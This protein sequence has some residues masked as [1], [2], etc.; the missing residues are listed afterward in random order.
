MKQTRAL[1]VLM[2]LA[3]LSAAA[4]V[5]EKAGTVIEATNAA[6]PE[7]V[8]TDAVRNYRPRQGQAA[9]KPVQPAAPQYDSPA[10]SL[11]A[12]AEDA[13]SR[14]FTTK[15]NPSASRDELYELLY[16]SFTDYMKCMDDLPADKKEGL[17]EKFR[18]MRPEFE[19]GGI[20]FS[21][22]GDNTKASKYLECYLMIP[23]L[24]LLAGEQFSRNDNYPAYVYNVAV[25][26][27]NARDY[28]QA[29]TYFAEY[30]E[31]GTKSHQQA[32]YNALARDLHILNRLDDEARVLDEGIMNYPNDLDLLKQGID[33]SNQRGNDTKATELLSRALTLAP[34]DASLQLYKAAIDDRKGDFESALPTLQAFYEQNPG[35]TQLKKQLAFCHYNL[36]GSLINQSNVAG[37]ATDFQTKRAKATEHFNQ[38]IALLEQLNQ[39]PEARKDERIPFALA[40]AY[41]QVGRPEEASVIKQQQEQSAL[42]I[43]PGGAKQGEMPNFNDW[44]KPR[45]DD[46][47]AKW[48]LRGEF[49]SAEKYLKRVNPE[50]RRDLIIKSR[51]QLE[52]EYINEYSSQY[53]LHDL[54][55]KPYDPDHQTFRI[56]TRQGDIYLQV[57][58][59]NDEAKDFKQN[60]NGVKITSPQFKVDRE[61][62]LLLATAMFTT[63]GGK[64]Y[65]Y[66]VT[67]PL[68]YGQVQIAR[69]QWSD[70]D[71]FVAAVENTPSQQ[72]KRQAA[73]DEP[74]NVGESTVDV[75][76]PENKPD[77]NT[78]TFALIITNENYK[79]VETVPFAAADGK[80]F[81]RY[82]T[83]VLGIPE[84]NIVHKVDAGLGEMYDAVDR[85]KDLQ[86]AYDGMKLIVYYS[87]H[88][89]PDPS[90]GESYLLPVDATPRNIKTGYKLSEFYAAL[91]AKNTGSVTFFLDACFSG[92]KKDGE[93]MDVA[94]RGV[95]IKAKEETPVGKVVVF[96]AC[97]GNETAYPYKNQKHG[98]FTYFLLK[99]LQEDKGK[100]TYK[101]LAEYIS[102]NVKQQS[103]RLNGKLQTPTVQSQL[104]AP[105]W[106][107]WRLDKE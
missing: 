89:L 84:D 48:E 34:S 107:D 67:K 76:V 94:A 62:K 30:I 23:R 72:Q 98:L 104:P 41:T 44:Y 58:I 78:N 101:K 77:V 14:Y 63:P 40:D 18:K 12:M 13:Y 90:N 38:A 85:M 87:G 25:E 8:T 15:V 39:D 96:S 80:S 54:T 32:V 28:E 5:E 64:S 97:T 57:P 37:D 20:H 33:L 55:I 47:L 27:H 19:E 50:T 75:N 52:A 17:K 4:Q 83:K 6:M 56:Q 99:K 93:I 3:P 88:G 68:T 61:G 42:A 36:A 95:A 22:K 60:W 35:D 1:L 51:T 102:T 9:A 59:A 103:I 31:L 105:D 79:N 82:C 65:M 92:T 26:L 7:G 73:V 11:Y 46:I 16:S 24:P 66:D 10:D 43:T 106:A 74:L 69:P 53:N 71:V 29:V 49:E 21:S 100:S 86:A 91:T 81:H 70:E 45:L 2:L